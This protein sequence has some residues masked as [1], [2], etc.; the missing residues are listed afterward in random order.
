MSA[1]GGPD[2]A[3]VAVSGRILWERDGKGHHVR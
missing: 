3:V 1:V 2:F